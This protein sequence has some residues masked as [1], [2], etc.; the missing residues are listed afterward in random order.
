MITYENFTVP[1]S[2]WNYLLEQKRVL[3][4]NEYYKSHK[5][6]PSEEII[7]NIVFTTEEKE[8]Y[9]RVFYAKYCVTGI[10]PSE[11]NMPSDPIIPPTDGNEDNDEQEVPD[12]PIVPPSSGNNETYDEWF[13]MVYNVT[14]TTEPTELFSSGSVPSIGTMEIDGKQADIV[15]EHIFNTLGKHEIKVLLKDTT[16]NGT[17][18]FINIPQL[19]ELTIPSSINSLGYNFLYKC[20]GIEKIYSYATIAPLITTKPGGYTFGGINKNGKLIIPKNSDYSSWLTSNSIS[21]WYDLGRYNWTIE[22]M[23]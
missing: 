3:F 21:T 20:G 2:C 18:K 5:N 14:T 15:S 16:N 23:E 6:Y 17:L 4:I 8:K 1:N 22:Y 13:T 19:K 10:I 9:K 7:Q 11:P 12:T